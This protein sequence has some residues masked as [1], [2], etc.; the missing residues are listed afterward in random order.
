MKARR[1]YDP[2]K[3]KALVIAQIKEVKAME[4]PD[5]KA[6]KM[7]AQQL[8]Q[9][10]EDAHEFDFLG[11]EDEKPYHTPRHGYRSPKFGKWRPE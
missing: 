1:I 4:K 5:K 8:I 7:L 6:L 9:I 3:A 2:E 11:D 10:E